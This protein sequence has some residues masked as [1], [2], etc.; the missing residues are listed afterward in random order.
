MPFGQLGKKNRK[1]V[2]VMTSTGQSSQLHPNG[3]L[4]GTAEM[5]SPHCL[6]FFSLE[7]WV[8]TNQ[9]QIKHRFRLAERTRF[10]LNF[11]V[12]LDGFNV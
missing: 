10:M 5:D 8:E 4:K 2:A 3:V 12:T 1:S 6:S 7:V 11:N 9:R